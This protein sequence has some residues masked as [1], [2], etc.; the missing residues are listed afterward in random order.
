[1]YKKLGAILIALSMVC[2]PL[3]AVTK[4]INTHL[5]LKS[6]PSGD[7]IADGSFSTF[8]NLIIH[9]GNIQVVKGRDRLTTS[10]NADIVV[11]G[12]FYYENSDASVK[13][14]IVRESD[15]VVSYSTTWT[16]RTSLVGSLTNEVA[17]FVQIKDTLYMNSSTDGLHKW[18]GTGSMTAVSGVSAPSA[19]DFSATT[20]VGGMTTGLD[21]VA[22][23]DG[24]NQTDATAWSNSSGSCVALDPVTGMPPATF[25]KSNVASS[26]INSA[27]GFDAVSATSAVYSY[28]VTK[29]NSTVGIES[30]PSS[31]DSASLLGNDNVSTILTNPLGYWN[32]SSCISSNIFHRNIDFFYTGAFTRTTG[33]LATA[34]SAPFD[35]YRVYRT[36]AGGSDY[37]LLGDQTTGAYTDGKPDSV[38]GNALDTTIDTITPPSYKLIAEYKGSLFTAEGDSIAFSRVPVSVVAD[39]DSYWLGTD[40]LTMSAKKSITGL[41]T[42]ANYLLVF[43]ENSIMSI[44]GFGN[45]SFRKN[46]IHTSVGAVNDRTIEADSNGDIIFFSGTEGVFKLRTFDQLTDDLTGAQV[47]QP[48]TSVVKISSPD[49]DEV[50]RGLD[51]EIAL[52]PAD[53]TSSHAYYD[54]DYN[55]YFL[56]IGSHCFIFD[57]LTSQ[58]SYMPATRMIDSTWA[59]SPNALGKGLIIDNLGFAYHNWTGY[60]NGI[61]SGTVTG[62]ATAGTS[63]TLTD[64]AATFN[65]T[66]DGL[67][68]LWVYIDNDT[69]EFRQITSNTGTAITVS[70][71]FTTTPAAD[72]VYYIAYIRTSM[73]SKKYSM[74]VIPN[75][76]TVYKLYLFFTPSSMSIKLNLFGFNNWEDDASRIYE[77]DLNTTSR[78]VSPSMPL[79]GRWVQLA[80]EAFVYNTSNTINPPIDIVAYTFMGDVE[81]AL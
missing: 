81:E 37:F 21:A 50:F 43:A 72:D 51:D 80:G 65:T 28:K 16:G 54:M 47:D 56:Y 11:N 39:A 53:Y 64:S 66:G 18:T 20:G 29:Y 70:S 35:S 52:D 78:F 4:T 73:Y 31:A 76:S 48:R 63:T 69:P 71:A 26:T 44:S 62:S 61:E 23:T 34:P 74:D 22:V 12:V 58:W 1:M 59:K 10:A 77:A 79:R 8:D 68:G 67:K 25:S 7:K 24:T 75:L 3:H 6:S 19:V 46:I 33:T 30:E 17:D 15:E 5:G 57:N 14:Y 9:D 45:D 42:T 49:L 36:V 60:E 38:L 55:R 32:D 41:H 13:K 27:T 2:T 40:K